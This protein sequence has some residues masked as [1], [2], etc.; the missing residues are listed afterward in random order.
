MFLSQIQDFVGLAQLWS[1]PRKGIISATKAKSEIDKGLLAPAITQEAFRHNFMDH[2]GLDHKKMKL[3]EGAAEGEIQTDEKHQTS[4]GFNHGG[5]LM[6]LLDNFLAQ[7]VNTLDMTKQALTDN[8][9][10]KMIR[11]VNQ[12]EKLTIKARAYD[13]EEADQGGN[14]IKLALGYLAGEDGKPKAV[15]AGTFSLA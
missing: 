15:S 8:I 13:T 3:H 6:A 7:A 11:K 4:F 5:S 10:F 9:V 12:G 2:I 1:T 14:P